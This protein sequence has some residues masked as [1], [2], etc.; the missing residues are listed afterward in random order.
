ME[1]QIVAAVI[2]AVQELYGACCT[3]QQ[4]TLQKTKKEFVGDLTLALRTKNT[5]S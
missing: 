1:N 2:E 3:Q 4:V 5:S